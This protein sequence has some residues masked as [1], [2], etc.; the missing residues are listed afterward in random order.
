MQLVAVDPGK[1][2][3]ALAVFDQSKKTMIGCQL[4]VLDG[5]RNFF[6]DARRTHTQVLIE[7][8][9]VYLHQKLK[10]D[11]NDLIDVA[12]AV[13]QVAEMALANGCTVDSVLPRQWKGQRPKEVDNKVTLDHMFPHERHLLSRCGVI[14]SKRHNVLDAIGIGLWKLGRRP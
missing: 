11:P 1:R 12:I 10:G 6:I 3:I 14:K 5:V 9:Q 13:G 7:R 4:T 8:P 2:T